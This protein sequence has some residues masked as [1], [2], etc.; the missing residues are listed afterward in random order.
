MRPAHYAVI[1]YIAD[2]ARN[3]ALNVGIIV[4][5]EESYRLRIDADAASR[6]VRDHPFLERDALLSLEP[7]L[8][9]R[10]ETALE[11]A[12]TPDKAIRDVIERQRGYPL[13]LTEPRLTT[14]LTDTPDGL[15]QTLGRLVQ[16][17]V[18]PKRRGGGGGL[19][20]VAEVER[21]LR[22]FIRHHLVHQNWAFP[23]SRSGVPR[24]ADFFANSGANLAVDALG[25]AIS[26][27]DEIRKRADAEAFKV[28]DVISANQVHYI[29][30]CHVADRPE[31]EEAYSRAFKILRSAGAEVVTEP[32]A[33]EQRFSELLSAR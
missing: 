16:R 8:S 2:P 27:A 15:D 33:V 1:R 3:E 9:N 24:S 7:H 29:T 22:P 4:W 14:I 28:E 18:M 12:P 5:D 23:A 31:L 26:S 11:H 13:S 20:P 17:L 10:L 25:L 30:Y 32:T 6:I 19:N 21:H